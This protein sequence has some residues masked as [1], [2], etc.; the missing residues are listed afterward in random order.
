MM[1]I[2]NPAPLL[3]EGIRPDTL[4]G[5]FKG[6]GV[7]R[8]VAQHY[9][10]ARGRWTESRVFELDSPLKT[11]DEVVHLFLDRWHP[12]PFFTPWN[13]DAG[14]LRSGKAG[15]IGKAL[16]KIE[17]AT[18]P[19]LA[20][21]QHC[22]KEL[23]TILAT[24]PEGW[25]AD[26]QSF[27][28]LRSR[29]PER[30]LPGF[31]AVLCLASRETLS[32]LAAFSAPLF[33]SGGCDARMDFSSAYNQRICA[34]LPTVSWG[35]K[36]RQESEAWLREALFGIP[37]GLRYSKTGGHFYPAS[38]ERLNS[39]QG[40][41]QRSS[42]TFTGDPH[43]SPWDY[44]LAVE[45]LLLF[46]GAASRRLGAQL[47]TLAAFPFTAPSRVAREREVWLPTW[48]RLTS[49]Q[50]LSV[51]ISRGRASVSGRAAVS[52]A[53]F[54]RAVAG[55][56]VDRGFGIFLRFRIGAPDGRTHISVRQ[57]EFLVGSAPGL[58]RLL[59][60]LDP[61]LR[62]RWFPQDL[63]YGVEQALEEALLQPGN[64][65]RVQGLLSSIGRAELAISRNSELRKRVRP[66]P[67]LAR[68]WEQLTSDGTMEYE[69]AAA[70]TSHLADGHIPPFR[71]HIAAVERKGYALAWA[72][73]RHVECW[74]GLDL[75]RDLAEILR[76]R[77]L[78]TVAG[79]G[80]P[81]RCAR[82]APLRAVTAFL[83]GQVNYKRL[84]DLILGLALLGWPPVAPIPH[85]ETGSTILPDVLYGTLKVLLSPTCVGAL[86][87]NR[88]FPEPVALLL[89][90]HPERA[91]IA[92]RRR[93]Q[94][95]GRRPLDFPA[96]SAVSVQRLAAA[97]LIPISWAET[98]KLAFRVAPPK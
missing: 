98:R 14:F 76:R 59:D 62:Q 13:K 17:A 43:S 78:L 58:A 39:G 49:L 85:T 84:A 25:E 60:G 77:C 5:Y 66:A 2:Q 74:G 69:I 6:L 15:E 38:S 80:N 96:E 67:W 88:R 75:N 97:L 12:S 57:G 32:E 91:L 36:H 8:A 11:P 24:M 46:T 73:E 44:I 4:G 7:L 35:T 52:G 64:P 21:V 47:V 79:S 53:D 72:K 9:P 90:G 18:S 20:Y 55:Y 68:E 81:F 56:G 92:A 83:I 86:E 41:S 95:L 3:L 54:A 94:S 65:I 45:G 71:C 61:W 37:S 10:S 89:S 28:L 51:V 50:E 87:N 29:L 33:V 16:E 30:A 93:L 26:E 19:A 22:L 34:V 40:P 70:V 1:N 48:R 42:K 82:S 27:S 31:D 63:K 23:R